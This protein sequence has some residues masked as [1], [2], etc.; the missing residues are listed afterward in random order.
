MDG[1]DQIRIVESHH[2]PTA[3]SGYVATVARVAV[4]IDIFFEQ[5]LDNGFRFLSGSLDPTQSV[6]GV[7]F[8]SHPPPRV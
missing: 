7:A 4:P 8:E 3:L 2:N 5:I 1:D 6:L